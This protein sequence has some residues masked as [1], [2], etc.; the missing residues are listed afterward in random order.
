MLMCVCVIFFF[1]LGIFR[2]AGA[3]E[4][5]SQKG[6]K[7]SSVP[8]L[9]LATLALLKSLRVTD[10]AVVAAPRSL[11]GRAVEQTVS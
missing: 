10:R 3:A 2:H 5:S 1:G 11:E 8:L 9:A 6:I 7:Q 4:S